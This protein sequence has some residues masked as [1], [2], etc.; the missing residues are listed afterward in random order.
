MS[1]NSMRKLLTISILVFSFGFVL[2]EQL[3]L[4]VDDATPKDWHSESYWYYPWGNSGVHKGIDIF[5]VEGAPVRATTGG[6]VIYGG[7]IEMGGNVVLILGPKWRFHYFTHLK[8]SNN[9]RIGFVDAGEKIGAV[10]SSGNAAGKPEHLHYSIH[11][12][13]PQ[14]WNYKAS[15]KF[16]LDRIYYINPERFLRL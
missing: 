2:P 10:G 3:Q 15:N 8:D 16:A 13:Y 12:L 14:F 1:L 11:S 9:H 5:A 7:T 6:F 4:P